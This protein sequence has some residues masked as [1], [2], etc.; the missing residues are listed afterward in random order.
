M[1]YGEGAFAHEHCKAGQRDLHMSTAKHVTNT[2]TEPLPNALCALGL[3]CGNLFQG[4]S[5]L[6]QFPG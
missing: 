4:S 5:S 3:L 6:V 2:N 1:V